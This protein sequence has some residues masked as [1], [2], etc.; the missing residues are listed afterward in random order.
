VA[1]LI[2][3]RNPR[4]HRLLI[5]YAAAGSLVHTLNHL[6]DDLIG[7]VTDPLTTAELLVFAL[8]L[9]WTFFTSSLDQRKP[10]V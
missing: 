1:L 8:L 6:Y 5:G 3:A 9:A 10:V 4:Q 7:S 2:A